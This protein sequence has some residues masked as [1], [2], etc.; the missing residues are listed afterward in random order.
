MTILKRFPLYVITFLAFFT[1]GLSWASESDAGLKGAVCVIRSGDKV[2]MVNE[3]L[4][5]KLSLPA[6]AINKGEDPKLT[7]VR[8]TW[9]ETGLV[10]SI[11][12][13]LARTEE[14]V[15][16]DCVS[17]SEIV[18]Y[19]FNNRLDGNELPIWFA[20]HYGIEIASAM[21]ISPSIVPN[22]L[23]RFPEQLEWLVSA[24]P[25]ATD[26]S[27]MYVGQLVEAAPVYNQIELGWMVSLQNTLQT[28]PESVRLIIEQVI[29]TG[30]WFAQAW[31]LLL[32]LPLLYWRF[33][34]EF[35]YKAFF[36]VTVTTLLALVAQQ[37]FANPRPHVYLPAIELKQTYGFSL[38]SVSMALWLCIGTLVLHGLNRLYLNRLSITL[39][40]I[41]VWLSFARF[42]SG[43]AFLVDSL[44]GA[45]LGALCAWHLIRLENKP[46]INLM[47]L[48]SSKAIWVL[49]V[50][51]CTVLTVLWPIPTFTYWLAISM[52]VLALVSTLERDGSKASV[53]VIIAATGSMV[54]FN[55][56]LDQLLPAVSSSS[57]WSLVGETLRYP[58][59]ILLFTS[60][61]R[62][63]AKRV[64]AR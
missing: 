62:V 44:S 47:E 31:L 20:P 36:A 29:F 34:K 56:A 12:G 59:T 45:L 2:V 42:Y 46:D 28:F 39:L 19:Q 60:I 1:A 43:A 57:L 27:V 58:I 18:A 22:E 49:L 26:Q 9:E 61:V 23:Y 4:T 7:A 53:N 50:V 15:I 25:N 10:V 38:P 14:T 8:E 17:D 48:L 21:L 55:L 13:E 37:G 6:G 33:G 5:K 32:V 11:Y 24:L 40:G 52:T 16:Y 51:V 64:L 30:D 54:V 63:K 35:A 3:I 41:V